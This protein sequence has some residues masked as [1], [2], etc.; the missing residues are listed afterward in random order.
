MVDKRT[1]LKTFVAVI[2]VRAKQLALL[3]RQKQKVDAKIIQGKATAA[4]VALARALIG[5]DSSKDTILFWLKKV[6]RSLDFFI[7]RYPLMAAEFDSIFREKD[8][9][10]L[11]R[12]QERFLQNL[13]YLSAWS[14]NSARYLND[15]IGCLNRQALALEKN[16]VDAY[17]KELE[18][19]ANC[20][21]FMAKEIKQFASN[22]SEAIS[23]ASKLLTAANRAYLYEGSIFSAL[24][25]NT[26]LIG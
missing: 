14:S 19:Q 25:L 21:K 4:D 15:L 16:N 5:D 13:F 9:M 1:Y 10:D 18:F 8:A 3:T 7:K 23:F 2:P 6:G 17:G 20:E 12:Y 24:F 11:E 26:I 22:E